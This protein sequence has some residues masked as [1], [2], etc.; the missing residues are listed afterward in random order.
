MGRCL[1]GFCGCGLDLEKGKGLC[2]SVWFVGD[3]N[4]FPGVRSRD[5]YDGN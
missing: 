4:D 5:S 1:V 2:V 3:D